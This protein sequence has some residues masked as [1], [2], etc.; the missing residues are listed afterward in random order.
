MDAGRRDLKLFLLFGA[1]LGRPPSEL[2]NRLSAD[3]FLGMYWKYRMYG[4]YSW[5][6]E[7]AVFEI[8]LDGVVVNGCA[9]RWIRGRSERW[10]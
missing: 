2:L 6:V 7:C 1:L 4:A 9:F 5:R 10:G 8:K 3:C